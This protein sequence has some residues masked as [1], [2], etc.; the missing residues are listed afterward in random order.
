MSNINTHIICLTLLLGLIGNAASAGSLREGQA[1]SKGDK[2]DKVLLKDN[3]SSLV[4]MGLPKGAKLLKDVAYGEAAEQKMDVYLPAH[5]ENAPIIFMVH[6]GAWFAGDKAMNEV[7]ENKVARWVACGFIFVSANYRLLPKAG[8]PMQADDVHVPW[9]RRSPWQ[10][11]GVVI[12][13]SSS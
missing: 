7:V 1:E 9:R 12:L 3:E 5:A 2:Q 4:S 13:Q 11:H 6:G 8:V 10:R